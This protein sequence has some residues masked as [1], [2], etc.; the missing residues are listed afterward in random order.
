ML[1]KFIIYT[2][3][4]TVTLGFIACNESSD[5]PEI[6]SS[7]VMI[8]SFSLSAN[9]SVLENLD[10]VFFTI[11]LNNAI[12]YNADSLPFG[13]NIS[14]LVVN[15]GTTGSSVAELSVPRKGQTDTIID[16][17]RNSTDSIDFSNGPIKVHLV[18]LDGL[19]QRDYKIWVN[20]HKMKPDS[21]YWNK[22]SR[23]NLPSAIF[24]LKTQKTVSY[25][26]QA[27][28]FT[29]NGSQY[30]LA[31]TTNPT[32][33]RWSQAEIQFP[34]TP[35]INSIN[36]TSDALYILDTDNNL[37]TSADGKE[38]SSC[39][40]NWHYIYGGYENTL[41]GVKN[42]DGKYFHV[43]YPATNEVLAN[44][45]CPISGTSQLVYF[46]SKWSDTPQALII[47]GRLADGSLTG[48]MWGYDG[49]TWAKI[50]Q[51]SINNREGMTFLAYQT[52]KTNTDNW[53]VTEYPTLIA[54]GGFDSEGYPSKK[55]Y[56]SIDMGLH[57]KLGDDLLQFPEY[58]PEMGNA[59]AFIFS[60]TMTARSTSSSWVDYPSKDLPSWWIINS[61][62]STRA[63]QYPNE[64]ECPYIY[65]FG[66]YDKAGNLYNNVWRGVINRLSFK[67]LI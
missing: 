44:E 16:Y 12:V 67:P 30:S 54:F 43:T 2:I 31:T 9:D 23:N 40:T 65:L 14:R 18:A 33:W 51:N 55:V 62:I 66:G 36:A 60:R 26:G 47:G 27:Y 25:K 53:S 57:W 64:W 49:S 24:G 3:L 59:Q 38:W 45:D 56:T 15:I 1:K 4:S 50:S 32:N 52:F 58:I 61:P 17:L 22:L 39:N 41:L 13:T 21:L 42:V 63:S 6:T 11:D 35:N 7:N 37:Y 46:E 29:G 28:C 8:T 5:E 34:F 48:Y 19:A 10:S 20:V